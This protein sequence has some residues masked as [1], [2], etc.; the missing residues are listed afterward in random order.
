MYSVLHGYGFQVT[1]QFIAQ[2]VK[3]QQ[4]NDYSQ[5]PSYIAL[6]SQQLAT[7]MVNKFILYPYQSQ[8]HVS[9]VVI[10]IPVYLPMQQ[11]LSLL[12]YSYM[13]AAATA[14]TEVIQLQLV[15]HIQLQIDMQH[16]QIVSY[17]IEHQHHVLL[18]M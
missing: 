6:C 3:L 4:S 17:I 10:V 15:M 5:L 2:L 11:V 1:E 9:W 18:N 8:L 13:A 14:H 12:I 16:Q 7:R